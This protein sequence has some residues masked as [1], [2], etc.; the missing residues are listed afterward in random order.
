MNKQDSILGVLN[1]N[2]QDDMLESIKDEQK[3]QKKLHIELNKYQQEARTIGYNE[4]MLGVHHSPDSI[5]NYQKQHQ[6]DE[7]SEDDPLVHKGS[8]TEDL[9]AKE[10]YEETLGQ[11]AYSE[12]KHKVGLKDTDSFTDYYNRTVYIPQGYEK[13]ARLALAEEKRM[14]LYTKY[15]TGEMSET[16]FLYQAYGKD[17]MKQSGHDLDS[18]LYWYNKH[19]QGDYSNPLDSDTFLADLI[20]NARD[21][22][23]NEVWYKNKNTKTLSSSLAG[24]VT[25]Q[26]LST[27]KVYE[28]FKPQFDAISKYFDDDID[29]I[30]KY[31]Q[32]GAVDINVFTPFLDIDDDNNYDYYY[33]LDGK[34]YA[35]EGSHGVGDKKAHVTYTTDAAGKKVVKSVDVIN[36]P[37]WLT[38]AGQGLLSF[39]MGFVDIGALAVNGIGAAFGNSFVDSQ[40]D[41]EA[42]KSRNGLAANDEVLVNASSQWTAY[43]VSKAVGE[44]AG[45]IAL[46]IATWGAG[47]AASGVKTAG[48]TVAKVS[49]N[50]IDDI[51]RVGASSI[52]DLARAGLHSVDDLARIGINSIDDFAKLGASFSDDAARLGLN[53]LDDIGKLLGTV[54]D[55]FGKAISVDMADDLA[56]KTGKELVKVLQNEGIDKATLNKLLRKGIYKTTDGSVYQLAGQ[57]IANK[58]AGGFVDGVGAVLGTLSRAKTG[59][60]FGAGMWTQAISSSAILAVQ[61]LASTYSTLSAANKSLK[62]LQSIDPEN[63]KA[64]SEGEIWLRAGTL[65]ATDLAISTLFRLSG[66][67]GLT[68]KFKSIVGPSKKM[69]DA[70]KSVMKGLSTDAQSAIN[71]LSKHLVCNTMIDNVADVIEN[72]LT[73]GMSIAANNVY[74]DFN[75]GSI[76]KGMGDFI[77]SPSGALM[78]TYIAGKNFVS[79]PKSWGPIGDAVW[80]QSTLDQ[81]T[82]SILNSYAKVSKRMDLYMTRLGDEAS[83][84]RHSGYID[85]AEALEHL[86]TEYNNVVS[87]PASSRLSATINFIQEFDSKIANDA[88]EDE[89]VN[90]LGLTDIPNGKT[91]K[92]QA[93][94]IKDTMT[95]FSN[96]N[97]RIGAFAAYVLNDAK[98]KNVE[99]TLKAYEETFNNCYNIANKTKDAY[100][101]IFRGE[102]KLDDVFKEG[103]WQ[104]KQVKKFIDNLN[105]V[106]AKVGVHQRYTIE[107]IKKHLFNERTIKLQRDMAIYNKTFNNIFTVDA[108]SKESLFQDIK[109]K[110]ENGVL[111]IDT[112]DKKTLT[113]LSTN[114]NPLIQMFANPQDNREVIDYLIQNNM[115]ALDSN[116]HI[117]V[118]EASNTPIIG[119]LSFKPEATNTVRDKS[120][121]ESLLN[122]IYKAISDLCGATD[123]DGDAVVSTRAPLLK[124]VEIKNPNIKNG[125]GETTTHKVYIIGNT[126]DSSLLELFNTPARINT[127]VNS[128]Y[129]LTQ[130]DNTADLQA[131]ALNFILATSDNDLDLSKL[132]EEERTE[133]FAKKSTQLTSLLLNM[134]DLSKPI[135]KTS[136][137]LPRERIIF[138]YLKGLITD[139]SLKTITTDKGLLGVSARAREEA[140]FLQSYIKSHDDLA[141]INKLLTNL[142]KQLKENAKINLNPNEMTKL[143]E[144][145]VHIKKPENKLLYE[146]LKEDG[147]INEGMVKLIEESG[148]YFP[149]SKGLE[150]LGQ[151]LV[152]LTSVGNS[153]LPDK[154][155]LKQRVIQFLDRVQLTKFKASYSNIYEDMRNNLLYSLITAQRQTIESVKQEKTDLYNKLKSESAKIKNFKAS[156]FC[157][158]GDIEWAISIVRDW[159]SRNV[160]EE[161]WATMSEAERKP[162]KDYHYYNYAMHY[163]AVTL[164]KDYKDLREELKTL[165]GNKQGFATLLQRIKEDNPTL[166]NEMLASKY[167]KTLLFV[168]NDAAAR[169]FFKDPNTL[170]E[171]FMTNPS[172]KTIMSNEDLEEVV[173]LMKH[174]VNSK[175]LMNSRL[176]SLEDTLRE[177]VVLQ[178]LTVATGKTDILEGTIHR[179]TEGHWE[180]VDTNGNVIDIA[181]TL[182]ASDITTAD[183]HIPRN[184]DE[185]AEEISNIILNY[186]TF[187]KEG[188]V[189]K[190]AKNVIEINILDLLPKEEEKL[191]TVYRNS[192]DAKN[193][194]N[195]VLEK[196][197]ESELMGI[198]NG[199]AYTKQARLY[200]KLL[201]LAN[202]SGGFNVTIEIPNGKSNSAT[203][204]IYNEW[205]NILIDLGYKNQVIA[206]ESGEAVNIQGIKYKNKVTS[207]LET[208]ITLDTFK[209]ILMK[210][211]R[212]IKVNTKDG[213]IPTDFVSKLTNMFASITYVTE[214]SEI[215]IDDTQVFYGIPRTGEIKTDFNGALLLD[216]L[217]KAGLSGGEFA[218]VY[219]IMNNA[220]HQTEVLNPKA[221][222]SYKALQIFHNVT[223]YVTGEFKSGVHTIKMSDKEFKKVEDY[224]KANP[225]SLFLP[226]KYSNGEA[227]FIYNSNFNKDDL[228]DSCTKTFD[229]KRLI[230]AWGLWTEQS[231]HSDFFTVFTIVKSLGY[232]DNDIR[233]L[234]DTPLDILDISNKAMDESKKYIGTKKISDFSASIPADTDNYYLLTKKAY[235]DSAVAFS[236]KFKESLIDTTN[237]E[238]ILKFANRKA[239]VILGNLLAD[240]EFKDIN[241]E[242]AETITRLHARFKEDYEKDLQFKSD[243]TDSFNYYFEDITSADITRLTQGDKQ[244]ITEDD[245]KAMIY[246]IQ[247]DSRFYVGEDSSYETFEHNPA[248]SIL[249]CL[250]EDSNGAYI[251]MEYYETLS[252]SDRQYFIDTLKEVHDAQSIDGV[253]KKQLN[254]V[255]TSLEEK[256]KLLSDY[257]QATFKP[258]AIRYDQEIAN[259]P[260]VQISKTMWGD[261]SEEQNK[262]LSH[263]YANRKLSKV[264]PKRFLSSTSLSANAT[265]NPLMKLYMDLLGETIYHTV[266]KH[267]HTIVYNFNCK[268]AIGEFFGSVEGFKGILQQ[269]K[270]F[271][272]IDE[273]ILYEFAMKANLYSTG[274]TV[275]A[276]Y[277]GALVLEIDEH[278]KHTIKPV[279][280]SSSDSSKGIYSYVIDTIA[281]SSKPNKRILIN[282]NKNS[283]VNTPSGIASDIRAFDLND[284]ETVKS[285]VTNAYIKA[286]EDSKSKSYYPEDMTAEEILI[287]YYIPKTF[288]TAEMYDNVVNS[289]KAQG[290]EASVAEQLF[291]S[292]QKLHVANETSFGEEQLQTI[293]SDYI[294]TVRIPSEEKRILEDILL[295][296][297]T[298][299]SLPEDI[300]TELNNFLY[301]MEDNIVENRRPILESV[302]DLLD[303]ELL[304]KT[305]V[306]N[307]IKS[308]PLE[309][310][311]TIYKLVILNRQ[312]GAD[313]NFLTNKQNLWDYSELVKSRVKASKNPRLDYYKNHKVCTYD[314]EWLIQS[315]KIRR[316]DDSKQRLYQ[317]GFT[318]TEPIDYNN[319]DA[320]SKTSYTIL[321]KEGLTGS[322]IR[323]TLSTESSLDVKDTDLF[324]TESQ[325]SFAKKQK[326][327]GDNKTI[328]VVNTRQEALAKFE[329][330]TQGIKHFA[331]YNNK[332][333]GSD[334]KWFDDFFD[335][336]GRDVIDIRTE[337]NHKVLSKIT[338]DLAGDSLD[339]YGAKGI[340]K[341]DTSHDANSDVLDTIQL[342]LKIVNNSIDPVDAYNKLS[343]EAT[344]FC[345]KVGI[346]DVEGF[347][348]SIS[349]GDVFKNSRDN[350]TSLFDSLNVSNKAYSIGNG[351]LKDALTAYNDILSKRSRRIRRKEAELMLDHYINDNSTS[352]QKFLA[353]VKDPSSRETIIKIIS[354]LLDSAIADYSDANSSITSYRDVVLPLLE[355]A[356]RLYKKDI[357]ISNSKAAE[358]FLSLNSTEITEYILKANSYYDED[359]GEYIQAVNPDTLSIA[360]RAD[361]IQRKDTSMMRKVWEN[362]LRTAES[363]ELPNLS[364]NIYALHYFVDP[365]AN[366][367]G[368]KEGKFDSNNTL[369]LDRDT[370][371]L[372]LNSLIH[373]RGATEENYNTLTGGTGKTKSPA[374]KIDLLSKQDRETYRQA[375][376]HVFGDNFFSARALYSMA[377]EKVE[378]TE[379]ETGV[380][381][382]S[383]SLLKKAFP[384]LNYKVGDT[385]FTQVWRQPGQHKT[386]MHLMKVKVVDTGGMTMTRTTAK[387]YFNGDFDGDF[388]YFTKPGIQDQELG[389]KIDSYLRA[390]TS[391]LDSLF[392]GISLDNTSIQ[393]ITTKVATATHAMLGDNTLRETF[394][395]LV[396]NPT[397][398]DLKVLKGLFL[399]GLANENITGDQAEAIWKDYG[400]KIV[401]FSELSNENKN[402]LITNNPYIKTYKHLQDSYYETLLKNSSNYLHAN[403]YSDYI[404]SQVVGGI[405][406]KLR[407]KKTKGKA[408]DVLYT[409]H[410]AFPEDV[411]L[412]IT[413]AIT[414]N[415]AKVYENLI[416]AIDGL[417][418]KGILDTD[419]ATEIKSV[420]GSKDSFEAK[421]KDANILASKI[422]TT[423][424]LTQE[425][426]L[427]NKDYNSSITEFLGKS[428]AVTEED[429]KQLKLLVEQ[430]NKFV[431]TKIAI[432]DEDLSSHPAILKKA[433]EV[434][435][436]VTTNE[437]RLYHRWFAKSSTS[438]NKLFKEAILKGTFDIDSK[439]GLTIIS[440]KDKVNASSQN[441]I[442]TK[443]I[444]VAVADNALHTDTIETTANNTD[445]VTTMLS[446]KNIDKLSLKEKQTL[447]SLVGS[448][449][450]IKGS[451]LNSYLYTKEFDDD[452]DYTVVNAIDIKGNDVQDAEDLD[453][454]LFQSI[455]PV[456][457]KKDYFKIGLTT[458]KTGKATLGNSKVSF[459][460]DKTIGYIMS[461]NMLID[462]KT[463][464]FKKLGSNSEVKNLGTQKGSDGVTYTI[465]EIS[466]AAIIDTSA[467]KNISVADRQLDRISIMQGSQGLEACLSF[468]KWFITVDGDEITYDPE[469]YQ[470]L[471]MSMDSMN[472]P[473]SED[474]NG[475]AELNLLKIA[476]LINAMSKESFDKFCANPAVKKVGKTKQEV[477]KELYNASDLG[478]AYGDKIIDTLKA[479]ID[480]NPSDYN[481]FKT[482][483][484]SNDILKRLWGNELNNKIQTSLR[485]TSQTF[486]EDSYRSKKEVPAT[487]ARY[488]SIKKDMNIK[489]IYTAYEGSAIDYNDNY[490]STFELLHIL[491]PNSNFSN[492]QL[493]TLYEGG[494]IDF[495]KG[496]RGNIFNNFNFIKDGQ[497]KKV[498]AKDYP[499]LLLNKKVGVTSAKVDLVNKTQGTVI[500]LIPESK[501]VNSKTINQELLNTTLNPD[502]I[503]TLR[504]SLHTRLDMMF[505]DGSKESIYNSFYRGNDTVR[506]SSSRP[507]VGVTEDGLDVKTASYYNTNQPLQSS[508][509]GDKIIKG[510]RDTITE[511]TKTPITEGRL[512]EIRRSKE[513]MYN[514][515]KDTITFISE[516]FNKV[517][518]DEN[519][520]ALVKAYKEVTI[521]E[522]KSNDTF[523]KTLHSQLQDTESE[524]TIG[525]VKLYSNSNDVALVNSI[526]RSWGFKAK[527]HKDISLGNKVI[528]LGTYTQ[529][530]KSQI[531]SKDYDFIVTTL[532]KDKN[533]NYAFNYYMEI[534]RRLDM[535]NELVANKSKFTKQLG[536]TKYKQYLDEATNQVLQG[537]KSVDEVR[538]KLVFLKRGNQV[539]SALVEAA[540]NVQSR[541]QE[542]ARQSNPYTILGYSIPVYA[543]DKKVKKD[544]WLTSTVVSS[545]KYYNNQENILLRG[546]ETK[547][548]SKN[549]IPMAT[550][551]DADTDGWIAMIQ[552]IST[553]LAVDKAVKDLRQTLVSEGW[554]RNNEITLAATKYFE[555]RFESYI[556]DITLTGKP[557]EL[558]KHT[559]NILREGFIE[560]GLTTTSF[561][562][563]N[564]FIQ[565]YFESKNAV[566]KMYADLQS[567]YGI[568]NLQE[569][570]EVLDSHRDDVNYND[571]RANLKLANAHQHLLGTICA[572]FAEKPQ[573]KSFFVDLYNHCKPSE[574]YELVDSRGAK[575]SKGYCPIY[576]DIDLDGYARELQYGAG[577]SDDD[578]K[579]AIARMML[580]GEVYQMKSSVADQLD[581]K[582]FTKK[583][584]GKVF[585]LL[586]KTSRLVT[587][588][589]MSTPLQLIDRIL[590]Y[591]IYDI[592]VL[593]SADADALKYI[594]TSI[595]TIR[596]YMASIDSIDEYS[597]SKDK[598]LQYLIRYIAASGQS[599]LDNNVFR[600]ETIDPTKLP[601]IKQ[602]LKQVNKAFNQQ[603]LVARFAYYLD[604]VHSAEQNGM[605]ILK[606]K[607]GVA[608]HMMD[609]IT[610]IKGNS[611]VTDVDA[612]AAQIIAENIGSIGNNP[613]GSTILGRMGFMF[614][615]FPLIGA[616]WGA[617]R[618]Q[619]LAYAFTHLDDGSSV[620]YLGRN[621]ASTALTTALLLALQ[622]LVSG[623]S[624]EYLF[625][626]KE[627]MTEEEIENAKN[628]IFR[629]GC[630][631]LFDS[632]LKGEEVTSTAHNRGTEY[633]LYD[634]FLKD[635]IELEEGETVLDGAGNIFKSQIWSHMPA[636]IKDPIEASPGNKILQST[637]WATPSDNYFD[638]YVRKVAGYLMGS[639]QA[640]AFINSLDATEYESDMSTWDRI[641]TGMQKAYIEN[642]TN[643]KEYKSEYKNY[644]KAFSLIYDYNSI[645]NSD[646][647]SSYDTYAKDEYYPDFKSELNNA[648]KN[649]TSPAAIYNLIEKYKGQGMSLSAILSALKNS[650]LE[651]KL[652]NMEDL[653][654]FMDSLSDSERACI[655]AALL[656]ED[657][658]YPYLEDV[659]DELTKEY[660]DYKNSNK[661]T[662]NSYLNYPRNY[663]RLDYDVYRNKNYNSY[664]KFSSYYNQLKNSNYNYNY[665]DSP[666]DVFEDSLNTWKYGKATDL[667]GNKY[668]GYT[669][670]K[671]D[672]WKWDGGNK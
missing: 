466:D 359:T 278:G 151:L 228:L 204:D 468:G 307:T 642:S 179:D 429:K 387:T 653:D 26:Q 172:T 261:L 135:A 81:R 421:D 348:K 145:L 638:N 84:L 48:T 396:T 113:D 344:D 386:V 249:S 417:V 165:Y 70:M 507:Y 198:L 252:T 33:H 561:K 432:T 431:D 32:A 411:T 362:S 437:Q 463:G 589:V 50:S 67:D 399:K 382:I 292:I 52:D 137:L 103:T 298:K 79:S 95:K 334:N 556:K 264:L 47:A 643:I 360:L 513:S 197:L 581:S 356:N 621:L 324:Y 608:Y 430:A 635:L 284:D 269:S 180:Y 207:G 66:S 210:G 97:Q 234:A 669:N 472:K 91:A 55:D 420:L 253:L 455:V 251:S 288:T 636:L 176:D 57:N 365:V 34:M 206:M 310:K 36:G 484:D 199:S 474:T 243:K 407:S 414:S 266:D 118:N 481:N 62:Y 358:E 564:S 238:S 423:I 606:T 133:L 352:R 443:K 232:S 563:Y 257:E 12:L 21:M 31:Y 612:Q 319:P 478:G 554:M 394:K 98:A 516:E 629:G 634:S 617:N 648:L 132:T 651:A 462:E 654:S 2:T 450:S 8:Y 254:K 277:S 523:W 623:D 416:T 603:N 626:D 100:T 196:D 322:D 433:S 519:L 65:A 312:S 112:A 533:L 217:V 593:G 408:L 568:T 415:G 490:I 453:Q 17:L 54:A 309:A 557:K 562:D 208:G 159:N 370:A 49:I 245:I 549:I 498:N 318:I 124:E 405:A 213:S 445:T 448:K 258:T 351:Q 29:K 551:Y 317:I 146:A 571:L 357:E 239:Q 378:S 454:I 447:F 7:D 598:N 577:L 271:E 123:D 201:Q 237:G 499:E 173:N 72:I 540:S 495:V 506:F 373:F 645:I 293:L 329:E 529:E 389:S 335:R 302:R 120:T 590:N 380:V 15:Q 241:I 383:K 569:L 661:K 364:A 122:D 482:T 434:I 186:N 82:E 77:T 291:P 94:D 174:N 657:Y 555:D 381:Y 500:D 644:K 285:L 521:G 502:T 631:K 428:T 440:N 376:E 68:T 63:F 80:G 573:T 78:T 155:A 160:P 492:Y 263:L 162:Y 131:A 350:N 177:S 366:V 409:S 489:D 652:T 85:K 40:Q 456:R 543:N 218:K 24:V 129:V 451:I 640:N 296:K 46:T 670:I 668:S 64:L 308:L 392:T 452:L 22:W 664:N 345:N 166:S 439:D 178:Y 470:S 400:F 23:Q 442:G 229:I 320:I 354:V 649:K 465:Y 576:K 441:S 290:V 273:D 328:F 56:G 517:N 267:G 244:D 313:L 130:S 536:E 164:L 93:K 530:Y 235:L 567:K 265:Y 105:D 75:I 347:L 377:S 585:S 45:T 69:S 128:L 510:V 659:I 42:W 509:S 410:I 665:Y 485:Q 14:R 61:D 655:K 185:M 374:N 171:E 187:I 422:L 212:D 297:I 527:G 607:A 18:T 384:D 314:T 620:R 520:E 110:M 102:A 613:Y 646:K 539:L 436:A 11:S 332:A 226:L 619:S 99:D 491:N 136:T 53:S 406:K 87:N 656:Y 343:V 475:M 504:P 283:F 667:Y 286:I 299:W 446:P 109:F 154:S 397:E 404:D 303:P 275:D 163:E 671:G 547:D 114:A 550:L 647:W 259:A 268:E 596:K 10:L 153:S 315:N 306:Y 587:S 189:L 28:L 418:T 311:Q 403:Q 402:I 575:L 637:S 476:S 44:I 526:L 371:T 116:G 379:G 139:D 140:Y 427:D 544:N 604:L 419:E 583:I 342:F 545:N 542:T 202:A 425:L 107:S 167:L 591:T 9:N 295:Y 602:Y 572:M 597:L 525:L 175:E 393:D 280:V 73:S 74:Q 487:N 609:E 501:G 565:L 600:G 256:N 58:I 111:V 209:E 541:I 125:S 76:A 479:I 531:L 566:D 157:E 305:N 524:D 142:N 168:M 570:Y 270:M 41:Y 227:H 632:L 282:L 182:L 469:G 191:L 666:T 121:A 236:K 27:E 618:L 250:D 104:Y 260:T 592:G 224:Y 438:A 578:R 325:E 274:T 223:E 96:D 518:R 246:L 628:I 192:I 126:L 190:E 494:I 363:Y 147:S 341:R 279:I 391:L 508:V 219:T 660:T 89:I 401:N 614:T 483:R 552:R 195:K 60:G 586:S 559:Y 534:S 92:E 355:R 6:F 106:S 480:V 183:I 156:N 582:V 272:G 349:F 148:T 361:N 51:V 276:E 672:T 221:E 1:A 242:D 255:I 584:P 200:K 625:G 216:R 639:A 231:G 367:L 233:A 496:S 473:L 424:E 435:N 39:V 538:E 330:L 579:A 398:K 25:G 327:L 467:D 169:Q 127:M 449:K 188:T 88:S 395:R 16:D 326:E 215:T 624:Q 337:V 240:P 184:T 144:F 611:Q 316:K 599:P 601:I 225:N 248:W 535:Y 83:K 333:E 194:H 5:T 512:Q 663:S 616:R 505:G 230:P 203:F 37:K 71:N 514:N 170:I 141:G 211:L 150:E 595:A 115:I 630:V 486:E 477:I 627:E 149:F 321:I 161:I 19:K 388:Y 605:S 641:A 38:G 385:F 413:Q 372:V 444:K 594:P 323:G 369:G 633:A 662:Y 340:I 138:L 353:T 193:K 532:K 331:G 108:F 181:D 35:I 143:K 262:I 20:A 560:A 548:S 615:T 119:F 294:D 497:G 574:G 650:S 336:E 375:V 346:D 214:D 522:L 304:D 368:F 220:M 515:I 3:A 281:E 622:I 412:R 339:Y 558:D 86:I 488:A 457:N 471:M 537:F 493:D 59:Q 30:V 222:A 301:N 658:N 205:K 300:Q 580:T 117:T 101:K 610:K 289:L 553:D 461:K 13:E 338:E 528:S 390:H 134:T 459:E 158:I 588:F 287:D 503:R 458:G 546:G 464:M 90:F 4:S 426:V 247:M 511:E 43:N 460:D 152:D